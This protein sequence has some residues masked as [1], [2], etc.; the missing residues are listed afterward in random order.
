MEPQAG[1][2]GAYGRRRSQNAVTRLYGSPPA[3]LCSLIMRPTLITLMLLAAPAAFAGPIYKWV[4]ESGVIHYSDQPH[5]NAQKLQLGTPQTYKSPH[6]AEPAVA[7]AAP[8]PRSY[9]CAVISPTDQQTFNNPAAVAVS[10]Q[11]D[12]PPGSDAQIFVLLDG[13]MVTGQPTDGLQFTLK[14]LERGEH[15]LSVVIRDAAG[16]VACQSGAVTFFVRQSSV[17]SPANPQNP[18]TQPPPIR[19]H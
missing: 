3:A 6:Y 5:E 2:T 13:R 14:D 9:K 4:D 12:P 19:P 15:N 18:A 8:P 1:K 11:A 16:K 10:A 17:L 7:D